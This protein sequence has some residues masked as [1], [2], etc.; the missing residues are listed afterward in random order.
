MCYWN[1]YYTMS[2]ASIFSF[3]F[4]I[5]FAYILHIKNIYLLCFFHSLILS[6]SHSFILSFSHSFILSFSHNFLL[7][8][9]CCNTSS[10]VIFSSGLFPK[11]FKDLV[12]SPHAAYRPYFPFFRNLPRRP[13]S[14]RLRLR[15]QHGKA[16]GEPIAVGWLPGRHGHGVISLFWCGDNDRPRMHCQAGQR[17]AARPAA[18]CNG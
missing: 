10:N 3:Q 16:I 18:T 15:L 4:F 2:L 14:P 9:I 6:F 5:Y 11:L 7:Y 1:H 8:F 12:F 17:P 13:A